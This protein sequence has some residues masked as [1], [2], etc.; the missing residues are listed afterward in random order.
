ME[1]ARQDFENQWRERF[2]GAEMSPPPKLWV[3]IEGQLA[4]DELVSVKK[5]NSQYKWMAAASILLATLSGVFYLQS[6]IYSAQQLVQQ[7]ISEVNQKVEQV[8]EA[9]RPS[10]IDQEIKQQPRAE[11]L[12]LVTDHQKTTVRKTTV[13]LPVE[14]EENPSSTFDEDGNNRLLAIADGHDFS[15]V[16]SRNIN[17]VPE[18]KNQQL[19]K[20][21]GVPDLSAAEML[22]QDYDRLWAGVS[23]GAGTFDPGFN[24]GMASASADRSFADA[25]AQ[26]S[27]PDFS[28]GSSVAGG[29]NLGKRISK[30]LVLSSGLHYSAFSTGSAESQIFLDDSSNDFAL[31]YNSE[32]K[33]AEAAEDVDVMNVS[34][35]TSPTAT[36]TM[37]NEYQYLT[38]PV[39]A[40]FIVL[41]SRLN[42]VVNTG[43]SSNILMNASLASDELN[44]TMN[45]SGNYQS[46]YFNWLSSVELGY[47]LLDKYQVSL[48]PTYNM[49]INDF[50]N[51]S[52]Q[53]TG[54]P[55]N[56]GMSIG[57]R[58]DF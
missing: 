38:I 13:I 23:F 40:G 55:T 49:A 51:N 31:A 5:K 29:V 44:T 15:K 37:N 7:D 10:R 36:I 57:F 9:D 34:N 30:R 4:K 42:L 24:Q 1:E 41:D 22:K 43:F 18:V 26:V 47:R 27:S 14:T 56:F 53:S 32:D 20:I 11:S 19:D 50:T 39:K 48:E 33:F 46:M 54:R 17:Y 6:R 2:E 3:A 52:H 28:S 16:Q 58:Y 25:E 12:Q 21:Y 35:V 45:D 8:L